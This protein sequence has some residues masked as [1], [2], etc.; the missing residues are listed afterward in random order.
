M[1]GTAQE[2]LRRV[3]ALWT[4]KEAYAKALGEGIRFDFQRI[5]LRFQGGSGIGWLSCGV[6]AFVDDERLVD[7]TLRPFELPDNYIIAIAVEGE[8]ESRHQEIGTLMTEVSLEEIV[9]ASNRTSAGKLHTP[10]IPPALHN[11][12]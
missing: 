12:S 4:L 6:D 5:E 9:A 2:K 8:W 11:H 3:F 7:W 10:W 1:S